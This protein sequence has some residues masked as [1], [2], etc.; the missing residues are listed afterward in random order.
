MSNVFIK[1]L[2]ASES[3]PPFLDGIRDNFMHIVAEPLFHQLFVI[4]KG[5]PLPTGNKK[6]LVEM[7]KRF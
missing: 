6:T 5:E 4:H 2:F 1:L 7:F 3:F